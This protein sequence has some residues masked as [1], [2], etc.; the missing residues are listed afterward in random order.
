MERLNL[1]RIRKVSID[2]NCFI[3]LLEGS[4]YADKLMDLFQRIENKSVTAVTS[5]I[6]ITEILTSPYKLQDL[7]LV[8]EYRSTLLSFPNLVF[9]EMDY[10]IANKTAQCRAEYGLKTPDAIQL[11]TAIIEEADVFITNDNDFQQVKFPVI[12]L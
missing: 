8:E 10:A 2:S 6:T 9:R 12:F 7:N 1:E 5:I 3:Y 11:A 4:P